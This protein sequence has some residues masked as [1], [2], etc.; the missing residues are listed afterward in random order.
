M[1]FF[2]Y[3]A[4]IGIIESVRHYP[5]I[6]VDKSF[7][8]YERSYK[9]LKWALKKVTTTKNL[10]RGVGIDW[11]LNFAKENTESNTTYK[12]LNNNFCGLFFEMHIRED[13][14]STQFIN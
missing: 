2:C 13:K 9:L 6:E 1:C 12:K 4:S 11:L 7:L 14:T 3:D 10:H 8:E 5:K